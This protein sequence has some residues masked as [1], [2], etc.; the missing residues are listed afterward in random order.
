MRTLSFADAHLISSLLETLALTTYM[1]VTVE[2]TD[3]DGNTDSQ[4]AVTVK[5][6]NMERRTG[7]I[8]LVDFAA[9]H[10]LPDN[11]NSD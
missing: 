7:T 2:V 5:V 3:S 1:N 11:G 10:W 4:R 9:A 8:D 6:T